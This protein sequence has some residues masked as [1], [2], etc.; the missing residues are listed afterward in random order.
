MLVSRKEKTSKQEEQNPKDRRSIVEELS[1]NELVTYEEKTLKVL[2]ILEAQGVDIYSKDNYPGMYL[3][4][5][6]DRFK[7][8]FDEQTKS[9]TDTEPAI[10]TQQLKDFFK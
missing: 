6:T 4:Q 5:K 8:L 2:A 9:E 10:N 3:K 1:A 7:S